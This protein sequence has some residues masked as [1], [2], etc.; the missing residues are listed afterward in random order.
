MEDRG[1]DQPQN[2]GRIY[3][4]VYEKGSLPKPPR[5]SKATP[6]EL[7]VALSHVNGAVR[8]T[9]QRLLVERGDASAVPA[10][11]T[12]AL[13]HG[14]HLA[15]LHALWTLE[16]LNKLDIVTV[17]KVLDDR[18]PKLRAAA[19][20]VSEPFLRAMTAGN[21]EL[22]KKVLSLA[23]DSAAD[24]QVQLA[25]TLGEIGSDE[26]SKARLNSLT[27]SNIKLAK[28]A[29]EF[30]LLAGDGQSGAV[31]NGPALS[32]AEMKRFEAGKA[33]YEMVCLPCHQPNGLGQ[34]GLAP[35]LAGSE[36]VARTDKRLVRIVLHGLRGPIT[37][38]K[39][40]FELD[41]PALG[42]LED[43]QIATI[44]TYIRNEWG[45][46]FAPVSTETVKKIRE[47]TAKREDAWT[48]EELLR[49]Q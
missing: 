7:V 26:A 16:G 32:P 49:I 24:V 12:M 20:R 28:D 38:K 19:T 21:S 13:S 25:L 35:P 43:E 31:T 1:L 44:L 8:D 29:A 17:A 10:L 47:E 41:M 18:H 22:R 5:L 48:Q 34:E 15:R 14:N 42:I 6:A 23:Q 40:A 45:N 36:W 3:R 33:N 39:Q 30:S 37:V 11:H 9:A 2:Q 46:A 27:Q 4:V